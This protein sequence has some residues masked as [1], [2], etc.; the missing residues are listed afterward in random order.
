MASR[1]RGQGGHWR[2]ATL[3]LTASER[4]YGASLALYPK[5]FRRRYAAEMRRDFAELSREALE[6]GGR[7]ELARVGGAAFSD[8]AVTAL[9][10]RCT[11]L[12]RNA[13]L[14]VEPRT[15]VTLT[16]A[17]VLVALTVVVASL[18]KTPQYEASATILVGLERGAQGPSERA[19]QIDASQDMTVTLAEATRSRAVAKDAIERLGLSATPDEFVERLDAEPVDETQFIEVS[20]TDP[21]P[22]RARMVA[23][24][25]GEVLSVKVSEASR[26]TDTVS[27]TLWD[28][29]AVP[30]DPVS[31]SPLRN[32]L[33][34]LVI[35]LM[36][37]VGLAFAL[38]SVAAPGTGRVARLRTRSVGPSASGARVMPPIPSGSGALVGEAAKEKE[39]LEAL[40]RR[41]SLTV[42]GV[43]LETSLTVEEADR[44]LSSLAA[45]GH[46]EVRVEHGRLL[47]ALW[48]RDA[49]Q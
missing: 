7:R 33:L 30:E 11:M 40:G 15:A 28:R 25:V 35:G 34:A 16:A 22:E 47:Y 4:L 46:L 24:T 42:A 43:A 48:E 41:G 17:I 39:L 37:C 9:K 29:A 3:L 10:E 31:P 12:A 2:G 44:M 20:Y 27:A 36:L 23:D 1:N 18:A 8:L 45:K 21:D 6:E 14:P 49:P 19:T 13:H 32:G 26:G 38:P 5:A